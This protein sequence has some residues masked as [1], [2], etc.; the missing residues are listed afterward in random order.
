MTAEIHY[1]GRVYAL[2]DRS[3][4]AA[5]VV[6]EIA[7]KIAGLDMAATYSF[8]CTQGEATIFVNSGVP[9]AVLEAVNEFEEPVLT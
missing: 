2:A 5:V 8:T 6:A 1:G 3:V 4:P 9:V 7:D